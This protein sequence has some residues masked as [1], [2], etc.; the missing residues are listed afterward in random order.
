MNERSA[1]RA[2][3]PEEAI[4]S[5][6]DQ[7]QSLIDN[8]SLERNLLMAL[9][10][11]VQ[12]LVD[13]VRKNTDLL[14]AHRAAE[15][16]RSKQLDDLKAQVNTLTAGSVVDA[17][18]LAEI[19]KTADQL[20]ETNAALAEAVP[21]GTRV[22]PNPAPAPLGPSG[23]LTNTTQPVT[24]DSAGNPIPPDAPGQPGVAPATETPPAT[25]P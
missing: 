21:A 14:Q 3:H 17:E 9:N 23:P 7:V 12:R 4:R 1:L 8:P 16:I 11:Q 5:V 15:D 18:N 6:V 19:K 20:T 24:S 2:F 22:D 25:T 10:A 13:E